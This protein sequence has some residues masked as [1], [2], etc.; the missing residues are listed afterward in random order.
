MAVNDSGSIELHTTNTPIAQLLHVLSRKT[1]RNIVASDGVRGD[2]TA[3]LYN[4]NLD[5]ALDAILLPKGYVHSEIN[6]VIYALNRSELADLDNAE[7]TKDTQVFRLCRI[8]EA[9][10]A[11][12]IK[13]ALSRDAQVATA[14]APLAPNLTATA[15][16]KAPSN[17]S[18]SV[19]VVTDYT[20]NLQKVTQI[21]AE[22]DHPPEQVLRL[23]VRKGLMFFDRQR[24]AESAYENAVAELSKP[25]PD[26]NVALWHLDTAT[27]LDPNFQEAIELKEKVSGRR[28]TD[29]ETS[30]I[31]DFVSRSVPGS[32]GVPPVSQEGAKP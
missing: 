13:P 27:N 15:D 4:L 24:L 17:G 21:L 30:M 32:T 5:Q 7:R 29:S 3:D 26:N 14:D 12:L 25:H 6:N 8:S 23:G 31:R 18:D 2:V 22:V 19:L 28:V 20:Q 9:S 10:A 1:G 11:T 16:C